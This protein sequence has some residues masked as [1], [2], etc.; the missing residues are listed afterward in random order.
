MIINVVPLFASYYECIRV[1]SY[2]WREG[3]RERG[4]VNGTTL[5]VPPCNVLH[6]VDEDVWPAISEAVPLNRT[7]Q[8][9][10]TVLTLSLHQCRE[11]VKAYI[12]ILLH[13]FPLNSMQNRWSKGCN[14]SGKELFFILT[15]H[16][17]P[18]EQPVYLV[19]S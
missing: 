12:A 13:L 14:L 4:R 6:V 17:P 8:L 15:S 18:A 10:S 16:T 7:T 9:H 3:E 11:R 19:E 2:G 5:T 1:Q